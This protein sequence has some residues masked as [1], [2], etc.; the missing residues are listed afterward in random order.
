MVISAGG[1]CAELLLLALRLQ[2]LQALLVAIQ[3]LIL[4]IQAALMHSRDLRQG[5]HGLQGV[6]QDDLGALLRLF[7]LL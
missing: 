7:Q 6:G 4:P 3:A 5:A 2:P 1:T